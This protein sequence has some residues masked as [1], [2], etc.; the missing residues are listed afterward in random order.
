MNNTKEQQTNKTITSQIQSEFFRILDRSTFQRLPNVFWSI[1][2][3]AKIFW[4]LLSAIS[5]SYCAYLVTHSILDYNKFEVVTRYENVFENRPLFPLI[6]FCDHNMVLQC[7]FNNQRNCPLSPAANPNCAVFNGDA[8]DPL[9]SNGYGTGSG[10]LNL[11]FLSNDSFRGI[12]IYVAN[13]SQ[14]VLTDYRVISPGMSTTFVIKRIFESRLPAPYSNCLINVTG[15]KMLDQL[16]RPYYQAVCLDYCQFYLIAQNCQLLDKFLAFSY[17]YHVD[18]NNKFEPAFNAQVRDV[19]NASAIDEALLRWTNDKIGECKEI[20]P[21]QCNGFEFS[22]S[23]FS[24]KLPSAVPENYVRLNI[25]YETFFYTSISQTPKITEDALWGTI[26][27]FVGLFL[28]A[29]VL[30]LGEFIEL[31]LSAVRIVVVSRRVMVVQ[32]NSVVNIRVNLDDNKV[33]KQRVFTISR[34]MTTKVKKLGILSGLN[35]GRGVNLDQ[36]ENDA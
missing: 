13:H 14:M 32:N 6:M 7:V 35:S 10:L 3:P 27:G 17:I 9:K 21:I 36:L 30:S 29:S 19:C 2:I 26:G 4:F 15:S 31:F 18:R 23:E 5:Y 16:K 12:R 1:S 24:F 11:D 28:G 25:F 20:C 22:V 33:K 8:S 34:A